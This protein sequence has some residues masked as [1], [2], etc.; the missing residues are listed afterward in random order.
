VP[1]GVDVVT[2]RARD[3]HGGRYFTCESPVIDGV[4]GCCIVARGPLGTHRVLVRAGE[5]RAESRF[6]LEARTQVNTDAPHLGEL[7]ERVRAFLAADTTTFFI[8]GSAVK[9]YRSPDTKPIWLRDHTHQIKA[10]KYFDPDLPPVLDYFLSQQRDDGSIWDFVDV[11]EGGGQAGPFTHSRC[12]VESDVEYL[13]VESAY[14]AWQAAGDAYWLR[15]VLPGLEKAIRY[16]MSDPWRWSAEHG[17]VQ[18]PFTVDTWD[19]EYGNHAPWRR[20]RA[21]M[22]IMHGDNSGVYQACRQLADMRRHLGD[23]ERAAE[24]EAEAE[25]IRERANSLC[26][27][28]RFYTHQVH[29]DPVEVAGVD[30]AKQL[31]LS[32]PYDVNRGLPTHEMAVSIIREYASRRDAYGSERFAEWFSIDPPFPT[33]SFDAV[34]GSW[35]KYA[36]EYTNGGIL[37]L[38]GG[39]L[40]RAAFEHGFEEYGLDILTRY[41]AMV[42]ETGKTFLWYHWDGRPGFSS[43]STLATDGWGAAAMHNAL[44]GG[45][46]GVEDMAARFTAV[47]LSPRWAVTGRLHANVVLRYPAS[48]GYFAYRFEMDPEGKEIAVTFSGVAARIDFHVLLPAGATATAVTIDGRPVRFRNASVE[49]SPYCDFSCRSATGQAVVCYT[50]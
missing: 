4:A 30:E 50:P 20:D 12:E 25:G 33:D 16:S 1:E 19:Y 31:S 8:G 47:R 36:G 32:N 29:I 23:E 49:S 2:I 35:V 28:G 42:E 34:E 26:W 7:S 41:G 13:M 24:W 3:P 40:S 14:A 15:K 46:A 45:L 38:V 18:R 39:E 5:H 22:C 17:L 6:R 9:G 37:P 11:A 48:D 27:N 10:A 44:V 21:H 43:S